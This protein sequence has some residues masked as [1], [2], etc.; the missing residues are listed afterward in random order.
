MPGLNDDFPLEEEN[1]VKI[2]HTQTVIDEK[3]SEEDPSHM[4]YVDV[5]LTEYE[6]T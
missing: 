2:S 4:L 6:E 5:D 3:V 1:V